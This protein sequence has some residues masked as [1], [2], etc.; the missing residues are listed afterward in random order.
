MT[1]GDAKT[2][3]QRRDWLLRVCSQAQQHQ[4]AGRKRCLPLPAGPWPAPC[5]GRE[6]FPRPDDDPTADDP[7]PSWRGVLPRQA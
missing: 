5:G 6:E 3:R 7:L 1:Q 2:R 4:E